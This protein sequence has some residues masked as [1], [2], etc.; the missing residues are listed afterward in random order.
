M[1]NRALNDHAIFPVRGT[2]AYICKLR[3]LNRAVY[4]NWLNSSVSYV[5]KYEKRVVSQFE[6]V[7][8]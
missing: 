8:K 2:A 6:K 4:F 3:V 7:V 1:R 5:K